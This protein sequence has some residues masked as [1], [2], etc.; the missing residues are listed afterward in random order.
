M[1]LE[2]LNASPISEVVVKNPDEC[3]F[4]LDLELYVLY[5]AQNQPPKCRKCIQTQGDVMETIYQ[6]EIHRIRYITKQC[7]KITEY[8]D[9]I[10]KSGLV[11]KE[12]RKTFKRADMDKHNQELYKYLTNWDLQ[13]PPGI[14][15]QGNRTEENPGGNG[16]GK[17][18]ALHAM[19][20]QLAWEG[21]IPLYAQTTN[22]LNEIKASYQ[23]ARISEES[24][25]AKYKHAD[26]LLW[27]D[28]GKERFKDPEWA[29][30]YFYEVINYRAR[31]ESP[32]LIASNFSLGEIEIH[33]GENHGPAIYSRLYQH[34]QQWILG[35]PD[36]RLV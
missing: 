26:V 28:L 18:Y 9:R 15:I 27:D 11:G 34:C 29:G 21:R 20:H 33:F 14:Y 5:S 10:K 32:L 24:I 19:T 30:Q 25:L 23:D 3:P 4:H 16:T 22:F 36:R 8:R 12:L 31:T 7:L 17:S 13:N 6:P 35:G 2:Q 1:R